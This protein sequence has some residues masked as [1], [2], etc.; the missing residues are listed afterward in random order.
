MTG[1][2][3]ISAVAGIDT[4]SSSGGNSTAVADDQALGSQTATHSAS[5]QRFY[6]SLVPNSL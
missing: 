3:D 4:G 1:G 5:H 2:E 6:K